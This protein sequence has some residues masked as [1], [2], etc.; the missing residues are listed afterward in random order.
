MLYIYIYIYIYIYHVYKNS[1]HENFSKVL[2]AVIIIIDSDNT[3][4]QVPWVSSGRRW[5]SLVGTTSRRVKVSFQ[6]V[7][8]NGGESC[9]KS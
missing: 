1:V 5:Q 7:L 3:S 2:H 8:S 6:T 9:V 4:V